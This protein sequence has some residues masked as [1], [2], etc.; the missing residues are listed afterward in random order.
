MSLIYL[1]SH[2]GDGLGHL[3]RNVNIARA[4]SSRIPELSLVLLTG[5]V[6]PGAFGM[7]E[8]CDAIKIP[9]LTKGANGSYH[10]PLIEVHHQT[11]SYLREHIIKTA[12]TSALPDALIVDKYPGGF[13][14]ELIPALEWLDKNSPKTKIILGLR[15][16]LDA[17]ERVAQEWAQSGAREIIQRY[18]DRIWLYSDEKIFSTVEAYD[19]A[20]ELRALGRCCGYV[21]NPALLDGPPN[22][23]DAP[24]LIATVGGGRDGRPILEAAFS[25]VSKARSSHPELCLQLLAGPLMPESDLVALQRLIDEHRDFVSLERFSQH[26]YRDLR[27][28]R[29]VIT[30]GGYNTLLECIALGRPTIVI[31]R[32]QPRLEQLIRAQAFERHDLVRV[33]RQED[34]H[35]NTLSERV[36][37]IL[38]DQW[39]PATG[40]AINIKGHLT[41]I[42]EIQEMLGLPIDAAEEAKEC[43]ML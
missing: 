5:S 20:P 23:E 11:A 6:T 27:G 18:Y 12:L 1:Y 14:D 16:V 9:S 30:M 33:V 36:M 28:A 38:A 25:A 22:T 39:A 31:P 41:I 4:A 15:D 7:P 24:Y 13:Q 10:S 32:E 26:L 42:Q 21:T 8:R 17:P 29:A 34:L 2:D 43:D 3:R 37:E 35:K 19:F 40:V